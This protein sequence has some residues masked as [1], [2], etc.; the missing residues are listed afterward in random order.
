MLNVI[1]TA[2]IKKLK[3][4]TIESGEYNLEGKKI[5]LTFHGTLVKGEAEERTPTTSVPMKAFMALCF[6]KSGMMQERIDNIVRE[7]MIEAIQMDKKGEETIRPFIKNFEKAEEQVK[8]TLA[9]LPKVKVE[10]K[11]LTKGVE[12]EIEIEEVQ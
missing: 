2:L 8:A 10:G 12:I 1:L 5:T 3:P 9:A 6:Q 7:A 4:E 11:V